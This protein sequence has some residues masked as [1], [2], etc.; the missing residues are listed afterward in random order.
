MITGDDDDN[1]NNRRGQWIF[2]RR[3]KKN[4]FFLPRVEDK[5]FTYPLL[6][7]GLLGRG[8]VPWGRKQKIL[9]S[10]QLLFIRNKRAEIR[11]A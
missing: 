7:K 2:Q 9:S 4:A 8:C 10:Q 11:D 6:Q 1:S 3:V 5:P